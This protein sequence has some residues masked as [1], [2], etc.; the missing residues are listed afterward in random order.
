MTEYLS[1][2]DTVLRLDV[3]DDAQPAFAGVRRFFRHSLAPTSAAGRRSASACAPSALTATSRPVPGRA[4]R[5]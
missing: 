1:F 5:W 3:D 4:S 2:L